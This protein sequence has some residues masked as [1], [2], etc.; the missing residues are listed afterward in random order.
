MIKLDL[1]HQKPL[2]FAK[3]IV[4]VDEEVAIVKNEF[5][6]VPSLG[7]LIEAAAQSSAALNDDDLQ[8]A[9]GYV[10]SL[11]NIRLHNQPTSLE[12]HIHIKLG[13]RLGNIGNFS[14]ESFETKDKNKAIATG[15]FVVVS[16]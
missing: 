9:I 3:H 13:T 4:C 1:P 11:K 5:S 7:M 2:K 6:V 10:A 14:F 15:S 8:G 12:F 16:A